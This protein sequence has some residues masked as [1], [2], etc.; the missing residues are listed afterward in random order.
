MNPYQDLLRNVQ[1]FQA[2]PRPVRNVQL[3]QGIFHIP[4]PFFSKRIYYSN[5]HRDVLGNVQLLIGHPK[6][7]QKCAAGSGHPTSTSS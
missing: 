1:V 6:T 2:I 7:C 3:V 5:V 4:Q